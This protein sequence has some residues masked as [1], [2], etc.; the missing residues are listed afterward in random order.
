MEFAM[1]ETRQQ[2]IAFWILMMLLVMVPW[3]LE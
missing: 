1:T 3:A 2:S